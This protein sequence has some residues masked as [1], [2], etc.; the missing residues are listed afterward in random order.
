MFEWLNMIGNYEERKVAYTKTD[1]FTI[2][3]AKVTDR[4]QP[5][6]TAIAHDDF[7]DGE[8]IILGWADTKEDAQKMHDSFVEYYK[9]HDVDEI[10]DACSGRVFRKQE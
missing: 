8:W 9:T 7:N 2:D 1:N 5:Y 3:T 6:E 4:Q 10:K